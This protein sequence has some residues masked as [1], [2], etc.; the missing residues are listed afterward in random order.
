MLGPCIFALYSYLQQAVF[1]K[2]PNE[3]HVILSFPLKRLSN[4]S[5]LQ[6]SYNV[7]K[8]YP[9]IKWGFRQIMSLWMITDQSICDNMTEFSASMPD[10]S[11]RSCRFIS[12]A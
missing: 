11:S 9:T 10:F 7:C 6:H 12:F 2:F 4:V 1:L 5:Y 3:K 8:S